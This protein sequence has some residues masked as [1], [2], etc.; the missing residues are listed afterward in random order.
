[1]TSHD[2]MAEHSATSRS[3]LHCVASEAESRSPHEHAR[4]G[5]NANVYRTARHTHDRQR[6]RPVDPAQRGHHA[7]RGGRRDGGSVAMVRGPRR[8][9]G[10]R[11][12]DTGRGHR[13]RGGLRHGGCLGRLDAGVR[14]LPRRAR[15]GE[16]E[17]AARHHRHGER[18]RRRPQPAQHVRPRRRAGRRQARGGRHSRPLLRGRRAGCPALGVRGGD[19]RAGPPRSCGS[20][21]RTA[22][23]ACP[24]S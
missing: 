7:S 18:G 21:N 1:M 3:P 17:P 4:A 6:L 16:D 9:A 2:L 23:R 14:R 5:S 15:P 12:R 10:A 24:K 13:C 22:S 11:Q 20:R 8:A 19:Q